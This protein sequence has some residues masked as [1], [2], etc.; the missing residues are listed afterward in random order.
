M[1]ENVEPGM[2]SIVAQLVS[3]DGAM[4]LSRLVSGRLC[5]SIFAQ[6]SLG[7]SML[8]RRDDMAPQRC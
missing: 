8:L 6:P 3:R 2:C 1:S 7:Q 4:R 5:E